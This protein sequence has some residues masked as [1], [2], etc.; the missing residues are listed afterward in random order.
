[1]AWEFLIDI[2]SRNTRWPW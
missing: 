1:M 2:Y